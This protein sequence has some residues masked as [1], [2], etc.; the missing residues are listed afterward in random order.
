MRVAQ[1]GPG[2][3]IEVRFGDLGGVGIIAGGA[4]GKQVQL[5]FSAEKGRRLA[6]VRRIRMR[7]MGG[8]VS[9][10]VEVVVGQVG[11]CLLYT[12]RCV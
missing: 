4:G 10:D 8:I 2:P 5:A 1:H 11:T 9:G 7:E 3:V 12:S 6:D